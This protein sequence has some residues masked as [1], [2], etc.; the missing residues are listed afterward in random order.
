VVAVESQ[1]SL[2]VGQIGFELGYQFVFWN[3]VSL[4]LVLA[5][6]GIG[7]YKLEANLGT[8]LSESDR[9]KLLNAINQALLEKFPGYDVVVDEDEFKRKGTANTTTLGYRYMVQL[10]FRF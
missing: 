5:G 3:R 4:D 6:P 1:T 2:K 7:S 10:G 8:N 9:E